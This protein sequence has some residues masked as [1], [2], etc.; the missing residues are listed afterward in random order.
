M[1][2][3][4]KF[5]RRDT[6]VEA[7]H[8]DV[9]AALCARHQTQRHVKTLFGSR[10]DGEDVDCDEVIASR[11]T[12][13]VVSYLLVQVAFTLRISQIPNLEENLKKTAVTNLFTK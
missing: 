12:S 5:G 1:E 6:E 7:G 10:E 11:S 9:M 4:H 2:A 3:T 8:T 13:G